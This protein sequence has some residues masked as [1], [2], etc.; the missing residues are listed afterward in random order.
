MVLLTMEKTR[1]VRV[2]PR[3]VVPCGAVREAIIY[4]EYKSGSLPHAFLQVC[5]PAISIQ[6]GRVLADSVLNFI[7]YRRS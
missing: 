2:F 7:I 3:D 6:D 1:T 4:Q 5:A